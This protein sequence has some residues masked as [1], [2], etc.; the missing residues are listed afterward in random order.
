MLA[1]VGAAL[2]VLISYVALLAGHWPETD[3]L[4]DV[5]V[6]HLPTLT[7][8]LPLLAGGLAWLLG[9]RGGATSDPGD[10]RSDIPGRPLKVA[11]RVRILPGAP[12]SAPMG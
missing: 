8:E 11:A 4:A 1:L 5:P 10:L 2:A 6:A 12:S 3:R 9:G 7:V